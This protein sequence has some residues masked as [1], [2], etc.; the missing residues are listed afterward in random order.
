VSPQEREGEAAVGRG[1]RLP[2]FVLLLAVSPALAVA[3]TG[4]KALALAAVILPVL[5]LASALQSLLGQGVSSG[6]RLVL[7][8]LLV[9][10]L[11]TA[12]DFIFQALAPVLRRELGIY[13]QLTAASCVLLGQVS[14]PPER[15]AAR[16]LAEA[17][18]LGLGAG[19]GL[20]AV[21]CVREA[22]GAGTITLRLGTLGGSLRLPWLAEHPATVAVQASGAL[23]V[24]GLLMG[25]AR[26]AGMKRSTS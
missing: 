6:T 19:L 8:I 11:V 7:H 10:I 12:A 1:I 21:A 15:S 2:V 24:V 23:L 22:L 16:S 25:L 3:T 17:C 26:W 18:G 14:D 5:M 13:L 4:T 20:T 9:G